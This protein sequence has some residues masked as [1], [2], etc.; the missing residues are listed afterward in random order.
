MKYLTDRLCAMKVARRL[1]I[2]ILLAAALTVLA[3]GAARA[4]P[5]SPPD[6]QNAER[7]E[8]NCTINAQERG[9][10]GKALDGSV[11]ACVAEEAPNLSYWESCRQAA[12]HR[13]LKGLALRDD[14]NG[15]M[16]REP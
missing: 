11:K 6:E 1:D 10:T 3:L 16:D 8:A 14:V 7:I 13:H 15:C 5:L 9:F 4:K 2:E 12:R